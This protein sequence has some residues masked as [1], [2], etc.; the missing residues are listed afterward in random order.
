MQY[1]EK[2]GVITTFNENFQINITNVQ[3]I[4]THTSSLA[5]SMTKRQEYYGAVSNNRRKR[6]FIF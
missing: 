1:N 5:F 6:K 4:M 2:T 3:E